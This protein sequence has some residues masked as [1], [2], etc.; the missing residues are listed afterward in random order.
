[1]LKNEY[2]MLR[3]SDGKQSTSYRYTVRQLESLIRLSEAM[4][5]VHAD[6]KIRATYVRE[7]CR[8]LKASNINI[9][10]SDLEFE[11]NQ[12]AIN[13]ERIVNKAKKDIN[14]EDENDL[15]VSSNTTDSAGNG[16]QEEA[17][18]K[19]GGGEP[20]RA[21]PAGDQES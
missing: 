17:L 21:H 9:M 2:K 10:K 6:N 19:P 4:A 5:R 15:F 18:R 3:R 14:G 8:L 7:V 1:M 16:G 11:E 12:E 13:E 20:V